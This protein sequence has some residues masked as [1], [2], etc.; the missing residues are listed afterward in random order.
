MDNPE[1]LAT[2]VAQDK[3]KI[4]GKNPNPMCVG[5]HSPQANTNNVNKT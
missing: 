3:E 2:Q 1:K 5:H 4:K